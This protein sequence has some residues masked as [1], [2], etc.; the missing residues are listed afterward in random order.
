[1]TRLENMAE[2]P[3]SAKA[4]ST[5][6]TNVVIAPKKGRDL[7]GGV[8]KIAGRVFGRRSGVQ[9]LVK[10]GEGQ[11]APLNPQAR[12]DIE[13]ALQQAGVEAP[14]S[15]DTPDQNQT[16][17]SGNRRF[18]RRSDS[19][20]DRSQQRVDRDRR[21][22]SGQDDGG[23]SGGGGT[24]GP[25]GPESGEPEWAT[26]PERGRLL[27]EQIVEMETTLPYEVRYNRENGSR[28]NNLYKDLIKYVKGISRDRYKEDP[29]NPN[30]DHQAL[31]QPGDKLLDA[32]IKAYRERI[33]RGVVP[34]NQEEP[35][36]PEDFTGVESLDVLIK[37]YDSLTTSNPIPA[38]EI[39]KLEEDLLKYFR[40]AKRKG[41]LKGVDEVLNSIH[42][43]VTNGRIHP[44][45]VMALL[46]RKTVPSA[47]NERP[48]AYVIAED[49]FRAKLS[50]PEVARLMNVWD[51]YLKWARG[52]FGHLVRGE[53]PGP[54]R[55][56]EWHLPDLP[57]ADETTETYWE[58][59]PN[60]PK[61]Y[62]IR[63]QNPAQFRIAKDTF[64]RM[65]KNRA[66]GY[67]PDELMQHFLNFRDNLC[68]LGN[69]LAIQQE[70]RPDGPEKMTSDFMEE[71]RQ[72]FEG[73]AFAWGAYYNNEVYN[74][75]GYKQYMMAMALHEGPQRWIRTVR[76]GDGEVG[77]YTWKF[78]Y[79]AVVE[80]AYNAQGS[81]GQLGGYVP[82]QSYMRN[83]IMQIMVEK[84]I[85]VILKDYDWR[86][87]MTGSNAE[88]RLDR[89]VRLEQIE[90]YLRRRGNRLENLSEEDQEFYMTAKGHFRANQER[91]GIHQ[92]EQAFKSLYEDFD[93]GAAHIRNYE[94]FRGL[95]ENQLKQLPKSLR[96]SINLGRIQQAIEEFRIE[97]RNNRIVLRGDKPLNE[98][99]IDELIK[100]NRL[101]KKDK[102]LYREVFAK[103]KANFE[104][105]LQLQGVT[106]EK[107]IRG[108]G[109]YFVYRNPFVQEYQKVRRIDDSELSPAERRSRWNDDQWIG[110]ILSE[111]KA[112]KR[113][114]TFTQEEQDLYEGLS[115]E[116]RENYVDQ[117][118]IHAA[119]K[120]VQAAVNWTKMK[121]ADDAE[122]WQRPEFAA[123]INAKDSKGNFKNPNYR[124]LYRAAM[125]E[126]TK[127]RTTAAIKYRGFAAKLYD[128]DFKVADFD[129]DGKLIGKLERL[130]DLKPMM[131]KRPRGRID[132]ETGKMIMESVE[133]VHLD[134]DKALN[135]YL[136]LHTTHTYWAYQNN[137]THTLIPEYVLKQ[138]KQIRD[139][140]LRP[141]DA[142]ILA[143]LLLTLDPT[144]CRV[145]G[146]AGE[147]MSSEGIVFDAAVEES[148]MSWVD[149]RN[150]LKEQFLPADGNAENMNMGYYIEDWGGESRFAMQI[151]ALVAKM[152]K[153]WSRRFA[154]ALAITPSHAS[155][156][157]DN[158]GR[159]GVLGAVSMM[160]DKINDITDQRVFSQ[161]GITK[162]I[163]MVD[164]DTEL[165][166]YLVGGVD[167][168]TGLHHEGVFMKPTNNNDKLV[169]FWK[170]LGTTIKDFPNA[171]NDFLYAL[172][173]S[174]G[175]VEDV[176]KVIRK[177]YSDN[178]NAGGALDLRKVDVFLPDDRYNSEISKVSFRNTG[179]SRHIAKMFWDAYVEWLLDKGP[180]GGVEIYGESAAFYKFLKEQYFYFDGNKKV[181]D[182]NRT[183]SDWLFDKMA[184]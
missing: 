184:L 64:L 52:K 79:D 154:A 178:R 15:E 118:P 11:P 13:S 138:A 105:A 104:I 90:S 75:D 140:Q 183:W 108:G 70:G 83:Q 121:Y 59:S 101:S 37:K 173:E 177:M 40:E 57:E 113:P 165:Y 77:A 32:V 20:F 149:I 127:N 175:R 8:G 41:L 62:I 96:D 44:G 53:D 87:T 34:I 91:I 133:Q 58:P 74:K 46:H 115:D 76:S 145:K 116:E 135:S 31:V 12:A 106:Q 109:V 49:D 125:V 151:E 129:K 181:H 156:M 60:Y 171:E 68:A 39:P 111:I 36:T 174:F 167:P 19:S 69:D 84:G 102:K 170:S 50:D 110:W 72:E 81:R 144:L 14:V 123:K 124:A 98:I 169:Q 35:A 73:Q 112:G 131:L 100:Q 43:G 134:F 94:R 148:F 126:A 45:E 65:I 176:L 89:A 162:F 28:L 139:G 128:A 93:N 160:D 67:A 132:P 161:F 80:L 6:E 114:N 48:E 38:A 163:N 143:G 141:E 29:F 153:R 97:V 88:V 122:I 136:A 17:R 147:Q 150:T 33:A 23:D 142:D 117:V 120:V 78:D 86:D 82:A 95:D 168:K 130:G 26:S 16:D 172:K 146:F 103:S 7:L 166:F 158:I 5:A 9:E 137:N 22:E 27:V 107:T 25:R 119:I 1:M 157:A 92:S 152:P 42:L 179:S 61:Y 54:D 21:R 71:L 66:L 155:T 164:S 10:P 99:L 3:G 56:G 85:G 24:E 63:A 51:P 55:E 47:Q 30:R 159:R 180:G 182:K 4:E 18:T 2:N